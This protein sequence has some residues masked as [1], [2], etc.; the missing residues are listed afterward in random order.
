MHL[1]FD[2]EQSSA[3][4]SSFELKEGEKVLGRLQL[5]HVATKSS[6]FPAEFENH[7]Y[8][9][10]IP[11]ERGKGCGRKILALGLEQAKELGMKE[12]IIT[13]AE[14]NGASQG[15]IEANGGVLLDKQAATDGEMI[16]KYRIVL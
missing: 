2:K 8:Y 16:R 15:V 14:E 12:V 10:I 3:R 6:N 13:C 7:V 11:E 1:A 5:R 9:E 4:V